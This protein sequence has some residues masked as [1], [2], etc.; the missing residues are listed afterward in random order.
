M[1]CMECSKDQLRGTCRTDGR[2]EKLESGRKPDAKSG[3]PGCAEGLGHTH[4]SR[5][6]SDAKV[7][8]DVKENIR[9]CKSHSPVANGGKEILMTIVYMVVQDLLMVPSLTH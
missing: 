9:K 5:K 3:K 8:D 1:V 2:L 7:S 4:G 6:G